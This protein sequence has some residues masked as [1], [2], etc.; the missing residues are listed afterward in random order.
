MD[1]AKILESLNSSA[2]SEKTASDATQATNGRLEV[3]L[4]EA[5]ETSQTT[6]TKTAAAANTARPA[7]DLTKIAQRLASAEQEALVKEAQLYGAAV[8][9][10]FMARMG[11]YEGVQS[12]KTAA[13]GN[14]F[15]KFASEN[16]DLVKQAAELGY[17]ETREKIAAATQNAY[18][19]GYTK[20]AHLV[21]EA[22]E[23]VAVRGYND[24]M[25]VLRSLR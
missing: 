2:T 12:T 16:P 13:Y 23:K 11:S 24:T 7:E 25:N 19:E 5:M 20:V 4:R 17:R 21:K 22:A 14:D 9:D 1:L 10:G 15:E 18:N 6:N 8:C 3:A